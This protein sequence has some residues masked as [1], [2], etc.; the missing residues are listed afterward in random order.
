MMAGF[1][2]GPALLAL[3][4]LVVTDRER[5]ELACRGL[6]QAVQRGDIDAV[7]E[8]LSDRFSMEGADAAQIIDHDAFINLIVEFLH[9]YSI[10]EVGLRQFEIEEQAADRAV[11]RFTATCRV[12]SSQ[13]VVPRVVSRWQLV[14][15]RSDEGWQAVELTPVPTP[16]F[17]Y[18]RLV[19]IPR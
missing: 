13:E 6:A 17:P 1:V 11:V 14:F 4:A 8:F 5:L 15:E 2:A 16:L 9:T 10:E 3:Q 18:R 7:S 12:I 19:D